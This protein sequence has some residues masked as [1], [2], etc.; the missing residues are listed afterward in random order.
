MLLSVGLWAQTPEEIV[1]KMS[2]QMERAESE[3]FTMDLVMKMP[4][5]GTISS[6]NLIA[7]DKMRM[8]SVGR[9]RKKISWTDKATQWT[10]DE[11]NGVVTIES[12]ETVAKESKNDDLK[13]FDSVTRG[14][15]LVLQKET[16][17]AWYILCKK[18]RDNKEK[19]DP[20]KMELAVAK[21]TYLPIYLRTKQSLVSVSIENITLGVSEEE[22]TFHAEEF[23]DV[24]I[25]DKR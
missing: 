7:G 10:Y 8:E 19:D 17:E 23:P 22:V 21:D 24:R 14:Y 5:I 18:S 20:K 6:H 13:A 1:Q 15:D 12:K 2:E 16:A 11:E 25:E 9:D 3:G 4:L